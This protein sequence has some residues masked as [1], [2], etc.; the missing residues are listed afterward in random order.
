[1]STQDPMKLL[2]KAKIQLMMNKMPF[3]STV[4]MSMTHGFSEEIPTARVDGKTVQYSPS[5]FTGLT[6]E[7]QVFLIAH[8]CMHIVLMHPIRRGTR[9]PMLYNMAGDYVINSML[10]EIGLHMPTIGLHDR[11]YKGWSTEAVYDDLVQGANKA[12]QKQ[13]VEGIGEDIGD[14]PEKENSSVTEAEL[15]NDITSILIRA[16]QEHARV[17]S[18][19]KGKLPEELNRYIQE[20]INPK[21]DWKSLLLRF[22]DAHSKTDYNRKRPNR[23]HFPTYYLP[24]LCSE[25]IE[26]LTIAIDTS[27]S[28]SNKLLQSMLSEIQYINTACIPKRLTILDCDAKIHNTYNIDKYTDI[29]DLKFKGGGGT[30]FTPVLDWCTDQDTHALIYFTDLYGYYQRDVEYD[31][32]IMW[33]CY[34]EHAAMPFGE[35]VYCKL[36]E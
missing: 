19:D 35:T 27:G 1:M 29:L 5:F 16:S 2:S 17:D 34:S 11:K 36:D 20:L 28:V 15:K 24:S 33:V 10:V 25:G 23:R 21:L 3:L 6:Q 31:F 12:A 13:F 30:S 8:E 22:V 18:K 9:D 32:P 7:E 26:H 4:V 14:S